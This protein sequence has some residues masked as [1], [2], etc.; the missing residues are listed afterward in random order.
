MAGAAADKLDRFDPS[1]AAA[2]GCATSHKRTARAQGA[3]VRV[4]G[5]GESKKT[6]FFSFSFFSS[7]SLAFRGPFYLLFPPIAF[8]HPPCLLSSLI[9]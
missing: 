2:A 7:H 3:K 1:S 5:E 9:L 6:F 4:G 8:S